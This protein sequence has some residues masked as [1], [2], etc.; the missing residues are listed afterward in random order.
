M[1][2]TALPLLERTVVAHGERWIYSAGFN[3]GPSL[4]GRGRIDCEL[5]DLDHLAS[6]GATVAI[7]SHQGSHRDRSARMLDYVAGYLGERLGWPVS[8]FPD[9][10]SDRA[11]D[12][13]VRLHAGELMLFGN[14]RLYAGEERNDPAFARELAHLGGR[15][16]IGGF[17]KAH[18]AHASNVGLLRYRD[19]VAARSLTREIRQLS[20]WTGEEPARYSVAVVG[21]LKR[22]KTTKGLT[23]LAAIY[24]LVIPGGAVLKVLLKLRG[25]RIGDSALGECDDHILDAARRALATPS[26]PR[27]TC[28][29]SSSCVIAAAAA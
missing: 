7:L 22:E 28:P 17:S 29:R 6:A 19:G 16:A 13:A 9:Y 21:G 26:E 12:R 2:A 10:P 23:S 8:Y 24:D 4:A 1:N 11:G 18:R 14:T 3:V 15:V 5:E 25:A 27:S 20:P